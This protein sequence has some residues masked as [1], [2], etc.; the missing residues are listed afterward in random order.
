M[1]LLCLTG[2]SGAPHPLIRVGG[3]RTSR[4]CT[5]RSRLPSRAPYVYS[6]EAVILQDVRLVLCVS[7]V[8]L[9]T[10]KGLCD[11][12]AMAAELV[13]CLSLRSSPVLGCT[14]PSSQ[15][16]CSLF[17]GRESVSLLFLFSPSPSQT[18]A[19]MFPPAVPRAGSH[20]SI[21]FNS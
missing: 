1:L 20:A 18:A 12:V 10:A 6:L 2:D 16:L 14:L 11:Q 17:F 8:S 4:Q 3:S 5:T 9:L 7:S 15:G 19:S 21:F 13:L